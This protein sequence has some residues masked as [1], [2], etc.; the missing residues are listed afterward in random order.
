MKDH[1]FI[2]HK[3]AKSSDFNFKVI[4]DISCDIDGP[5]ASTIRSST[6]ENPIYGYN[7]YTEKRSKFR[8]DSAIAVMAVSNLPCELPRCF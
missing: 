1:L 7:P 3:D 8:E 2:A 5:I 6:I 4:A